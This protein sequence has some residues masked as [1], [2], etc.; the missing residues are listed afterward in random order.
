MVNAETRQKAEELAAQSKR[1]IDQ[2][3]LSQNTLDVIL[4]DVK[5]LAAQTDIWS[6]DNFPEPEEGVQ[7][8]RYLIREDPD[9]TFALYLNV[10]RPGKRIPPH[11]HTTWACIAAVEGV[12]TNHVYERL[13]DGTK[14][15][16]AKLAQAREVR[17]EPGTG[18]ALM[19]DDIHSVF[20]DGEDIIRHLHFYGN[21]LETLQD[22]L[23]FNVAE[24]SV[25]AM[26]IG[27]QTRR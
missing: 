24:S 5:A 12:E 14:P 10:M 21:A 16:Y 22:R 23:V 19:P 20:I 6:V 9:R 8:A 15:G 18:L 11:N 17:I 26:D 13:D 4:E 27:V 7:Q 25:K 1:R 2:D 3:G